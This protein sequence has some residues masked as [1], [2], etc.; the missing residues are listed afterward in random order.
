MTLYKTEAII[1]RK[2]PL[3]EADQI[4]TF[5]SPEHGKFDAVAKGI[6]KV[7]STFSGKLELFCRVRLLAAEG[8]NLD[9][10][11]QA[12]LLNPRKGINKDIAHF[13]YASLVLEL[14][15]LF[16]EEGEKNRTLFNLLD[17]TL[18]S[19]ERKKNL[20]LVLIIF[21]IK[22]LRILGY[23]PEIKKCIICSSAISL[24][25]FSPSGGGAVCGLCRGNVKDAIPAG[26]S[27]FKIIDT[28]RK[29]PLN[30]SQ[31]VN[32]S[33]MQVADTEKILERHVKYRLEREIKSLVFIKEVLNK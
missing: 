32:L 31:R 7:K 2:R 12:E 8:K 10:I 22:L 25:F 20:K 28:F 21:Q 1:L 24:S 3:G 13:A 6:R 27:V 5:I 14:V 16:T 9:T 18:E 19:L 29:L 4:I 30:S 23:M 15:D 26:E 17:L 33:A 11:S